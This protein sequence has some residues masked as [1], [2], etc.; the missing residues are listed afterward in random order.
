MS[1]PLVVIALFPVWLAVALV[2]SAARQ[3]INPTIP[4]EEPLKLRNPLR[5]S[6]VF[7]LVGLLASSAAA[8]GSD[9]V[10]WALSER[11]R[12]EGGRL[13]LKEVE[14]GKGFFGFTLHG[15]FRPRYLR[16][17][18]R[19]VLFKL[20]TKGGRRWDRFVAFD[21]V[22]VT[23]C[24]LT[25]RGSLERFGRVLREGRRLMCS[26]RWRHRKRHWSWKVVSRYK[27]KDRAPNRGRYRFG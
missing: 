5:K 11:D 3:A 21:R 8:H 17:P 27:R 12:R 2:I 16:G 20:D 14:V 7:L 9:D 4:R 19:Y 24:V 26:V 18:N 15:R 23:S 1:V 13:D 25:G 6:V 10:S 22:N